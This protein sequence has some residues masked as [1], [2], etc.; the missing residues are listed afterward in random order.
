MCSTTLLASSFCRRR[1]FRSATFAGRSWCPEV[2]LRFRDLTFRDRSEVESRIPKPTSGH[3][4]RVT[5]WCPEVGLGILDFA[6]RR[7]AVREGRDARP[8][9]RVF[10]GDII[11]EDADHSLVWNLDLT[12]PW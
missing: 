2:G 7:R 1:F 12:L 10:I 9:C 4:D 6:C 11:G 3:L 8:L 5:C